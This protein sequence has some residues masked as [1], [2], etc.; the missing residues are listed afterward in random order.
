M[1]TKKPYTRRSPE[2]WQAIINNFSTSGLTLNEYCQQHSIALSGFYAW[3]KRLQQQNLPETA[4]PK[5][6]EITPEF[7]A[8]TKQTHDSNTWQ[9]ELEL[10]GGCILRLRTA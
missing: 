5:L 7:T 10:G 3:R 1:T 9:V 6:I 2:Q 8:P 4:T